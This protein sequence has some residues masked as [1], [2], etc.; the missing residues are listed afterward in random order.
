MRGF[1]W[2]RRGLAEMFNARKHLTGHGVCWRN[3]DGA[4]AQTQTVATWRARSLDNKFGSCRTVALGRK[5]QTADK[6]KHH[7]CNEEG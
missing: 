7:A 2:G 6:E 1:A 5:A 3:R 4:T